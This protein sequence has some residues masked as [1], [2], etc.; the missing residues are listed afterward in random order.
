MKRTSPSATARPAVRPAGNGAPT[1][2]TPFAY[3]T[4]PVSRAASRKSVTISMVVLGAV[5]AGPGGRGGLP[6]L[7]QAR[8]LWP[9]STAP[10]TRRRRRRLRSRRLP[11][12]NPL[13]RPPRRRLR[14]PRRRPPA[15]PRSPTPCRPSSRP[16]P[17]GARDAPPRQAGWGGVRLHAE[18]PAKDTI[19]ASRPRNKAD[20]LFD[21]V[22]GTRTGRSRP[23]SGDKGKKTAYV[24]PAP[25]VEP[26]SRSGSPMETSCPSSWPTRAPSSAA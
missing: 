6:D 26:T 11:R 4:P 16:R 18:G 2:P 15:W 17:D 3:R 10:S 19:E 13:W 1:V 5:V 7:P 12:P 25:G 9:S 21:E 22:F 14:P 23:P 8:R 20:D 24:P